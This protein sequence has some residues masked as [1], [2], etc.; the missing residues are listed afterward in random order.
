LVRWT[1]FGALMGEL[2]SARFDVELAES[3]SPRPPS[4]QVRDARVAVDRAG[5]SVHSLL[6]ADDDG[7]ASAIAVART[8]VNQA[9][10]M[11]AVAR[12]LAAEARASRQMVQRIQ[13]QVEGQRGPKRDDEP[14][15]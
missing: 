6:Y 11:A 1:D 3:D 4:Q 15:Q 7:V 14:R 12:R 2:E 5:E 13:R 9:R 10:A 8:Q